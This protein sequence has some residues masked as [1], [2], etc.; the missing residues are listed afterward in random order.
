M[1]LNHFCAIDCVN[2]ISCFS[3]QK[4]LDI[5][6][7]FLYGAEYIFTSFRFNFLIKILYCDICICWL[8]F[9]CVWLELEYL[10]LFWIKPHRT[11]FPPQNQQK[12]L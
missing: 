8:L 2:L 9:I 5:F 6:N 12:K 1:C 11:I 10:C 4:L 3:F 7:I